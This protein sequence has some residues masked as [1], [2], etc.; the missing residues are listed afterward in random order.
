MSKEESKRLE[1]L[2]LKFVDRK[3]LNAFVEAYTQ[4]TV[5]NGPSVKDSRLEALGIKR[6]DR[7]FASPY[8][9]I[10]IISLVLPVGDSKKHWVVENFK[11]LITYADS[12]V[13]TLFEAVELVVQAYRFAYD[14]KFRNSG[15]SAAASKNSNV[16]E[17]NLKTLVEN[18]RLFWE[19]WR[20]PAPDGSIV[21]S[22]TWFSHEPGDVFS[23]V[24]MM[25]ELRKRVNLQ[26]DGNFDRQA[27]GN[28]TT[29]IPTYDEWT[30]CDDSD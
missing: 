27:A 10:R 17:L 22:L 23:L 1:N 28:M 5:V 19:L 16:F 6:W 30:M 9:N 15:T 25:D 3:D 24:A 13:K 11:K 29:N 18:G 4:G 21:P 20:L 2:L 26:K 7:F 12:K 14:K 8:E